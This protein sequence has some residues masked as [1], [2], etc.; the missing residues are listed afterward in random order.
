MCLKSAIATRRTEGGANG[1]SRLVSSNRISIVRQHN[2]AL[3]REL[4]AAGIAIFPTR[5]K[6][7]LIKGWRTTASFERDQVEQWWRLYPDAAPGIE[8]SMSSLIVLDC[9]RHPG[10]PD[11]VAAFEPLIAERRL[12]EHPITAT[13]GGGFHHF[14]RQPDRGKPLG[15]GTGKLPPGIDVRA[16]GG[17]IVGPN[18]MRLDGGVYKPVEGTPTLIDLYQRDAVPRL[19]KWLHELLRPPPVRRLTTYQPRDDD[20]QRVADAL[21]RIPSDD[22]E[23]W[24]RVGMA[25]KHRFGDAGYEMWCWWSARCEQKFNAAVQADTWRGFQRDGVTIATV[26]H[27]AK[28]HQHVG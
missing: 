2:G 24:L 19:P 10:A 6:V 4:V 16:N 26:F 11:G 23:V 17:Y 8:L 28:E 14:F 5:D 3:A 22:R 7:P 27:L 13:P 21:R 1:V 25:L 12:P 15:C 9:D 20:Q 18:S